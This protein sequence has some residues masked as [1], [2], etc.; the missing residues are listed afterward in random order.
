MFQVKITSA[1]KTILVSL[2]EPALLSN[3]LSDQKIHI[4]MPCAGRGKCLK[5]KVRAIGLLSDIT[6]AELGALSEEEREMGVRLAC[7]TYVVGNAEIRL[8]DEN[9]KSSK[10]VSG[11]HMPYF[12][13]HPLGEKF[14]IAI[15]IGTT[16]VAAYLYN[17]SN[18]SQIG[19]SCANNP[20][21]RSAPMSFRALKNR[22]Q[23]IPSSLRRQSLTVSSNYQATCANHRIFLLL[24]LTAW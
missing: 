18:R 4:A 3:L 19:S 15:D 8:F 2:S 22:W 20:Q 9:E 23:E 13:T 16:T 12:E 14:G 10:I 6:E 7:M 17:L 11:G 24:I 21:K 5:C 1:D